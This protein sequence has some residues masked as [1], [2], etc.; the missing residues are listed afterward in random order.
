MWELMYS[1]RAFL[2]DTIEIDDRDE[3]AAVIESICLEKAR[4]EYMAAPMTDQINV[5]AID[6]NGRNRLVAVYMA[7]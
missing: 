7:G 1:R 6:S 2:P 5:Y 3:A 4:V